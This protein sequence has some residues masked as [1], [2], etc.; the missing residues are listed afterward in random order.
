MSQRESNDPPLWKIL[1]TILVFLAYGVG[2]Q[3]AAFFLAGWLGPKLA[4]DLSPVARQVVTSFMGLLL[5]AVPP[6]T[7]GLMQRPREMATWQA[8]LAA[9]V[10][11]SKGDFRTR[12]ELV[13]IR[14]ANNHPFVQLAHNLNDM[15]AEL[16][17]LEAMRQE[18]ISDVSHEL[19]SPL[20]S[21]R[22][23]AKALQEEDLA[24]ADRQRYLGIIEVEAERL[25]RLS[26]NLLRLTALEADAPVMHPAPYR[27]DQQLR[28]ILLATEPQWTAKRLGV[29]ASLEDTR[30]VADQELLDRVWTNLVHNAVKFTPE[31][32][33]ITVR[34][35]RQGAEIVVEVR[36]T[37][38][39]IALEDQPRVFERFFKADKSRHRDA[40]GSGT[41]SGTGSG[42]G[43][44]LA[45]AR[46]I[47]SLHEGRIELQSA[48]GRGSTFTVTLPAAE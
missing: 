6:M 33:A 17:R 4:V 20:T 14:G 29:E 30:I 8:L 41:G 3:V 43:L 21:I 19:Q 9:V 16:G 24:R 36:D 5:M 23:F 39:G 10:R 34:T 28:R 40:S 35:E 37:G 38:I 42:S 31:G 12:V 44:G 2:C 1:L 15:A 32:G 26:D 45:L 22:G 47:V 18:F 27:L 25:S 46:K 13:P 11:I 7:F 48:P